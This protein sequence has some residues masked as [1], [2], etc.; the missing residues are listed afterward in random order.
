MQLFRLRPTTQKMSLFAARTCNS[1]ASRSHTRS[2]RCS[3]FNC[4]FFNTGSLLHKCKKHSIAAK[5]P[6]MIFCS[7]ANCFKP[8]SII[9]FALK[10]N[11]KKSWGKLTC[12]SRWHLDSSVIIVSL[13]CWLSLNWSGSKI[14]KLAKSET[15]MRPSKD[16]SKFQ[17]RSR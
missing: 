12:H 7:F 14:K 15:E 2:A 5:Y 4:I 11:K 3:F 8:F 17:D 9:D 10:K 13:P 6:Q 16:A 1:S